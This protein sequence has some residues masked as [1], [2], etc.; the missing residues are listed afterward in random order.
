MSFIVAP[1]V[2]AVVHTTAVSIS[3]IAWYAAGGIWWAG[4]RLIYGYQK[5]PQERQLELDER[6][7]AQLTRQTQILETLQYSPGPPDVRLING[8]FLIE[9]AISDGRVS[10]IEDI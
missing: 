2:Q 4:K 9:D 3:S 10:L 8:T 5:T 7:L 6:I 1:I